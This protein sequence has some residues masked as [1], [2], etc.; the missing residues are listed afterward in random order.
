MYIVVEILF[1]FS[2]RPT[3][4]FGMIEGEIVEIFCILNLV[5]FV[6]SSLR[7]SRP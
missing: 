2:Q 6:E 4:R 5:G 7:A 1:N 3:T